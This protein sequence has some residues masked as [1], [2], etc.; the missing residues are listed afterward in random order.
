VAG[1]QS[2]AA[3]AR[4]VRRR[5]RCLIRTQ[6]DLVERVLQAVTPAFAARGFVRVD[7]TFR[8]ELADMYW[9]V[10]FAFVRHPGDVDVICD[11]AVRHH[12]LQDVLRPKLYPTFKDRE[13]RQTATVGAELGNYCGQGQRRWPIRGD[14]DIS[15]F[16]KDLEYWYPEQI[17]IGL[18]S[19][20]DLPGVLESLEPNDAFARLLCPVPGQREALIEAIRSALRPRAV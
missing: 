19:L 12:A 9:L 17:L 3:E 5:V 11:F 8:R 14:S 6:P 4:F 15:S 10:H 13:F 20:S 1:G 16:V 7:Q 18:E 2:P